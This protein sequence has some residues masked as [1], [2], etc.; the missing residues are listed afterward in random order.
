MEVSDEKREQFFIYIALSSPNVHRLH[1]CCCR[2]RGNPAVGKKVPHEMK[3]FGDVCGDDYYW[4]RDDSCSNPE[5]LSYLKEE[6]NHTDQAMLGVKQFEDGL[7]A[8]MRARIKEDD[9][10]VPIR[11]GSYYYYERTLKGKEY[12]LHCRRL[13]TDD[14]S[15]S[16]HDVMPMGP[17]AAEEHVILDENIKSQGH[18]YYSIWAFIRLLHSYLTSVT[19]LQ[20]CPQ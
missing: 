15:A 6:N 16:A 9:I 7:F 18:N 20:I 17:G 12:V 2:L 1:E 8:K 11:R 4:L 3:M 13:I 10:S 14:T 19:C 5:I